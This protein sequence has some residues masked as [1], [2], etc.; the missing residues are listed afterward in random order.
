MDDVHRTLGTSCSWDALY[1]LTALP[2]LIQKVA[3][4]I[5]KSRRAFNNCSASTADND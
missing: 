2:V 1:L 3:S 4:D 5:N